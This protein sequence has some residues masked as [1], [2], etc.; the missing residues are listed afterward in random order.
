MC[1]GLCRL[2]HLQEFSEVIQVSDEREQFKEIRDFWR[3]W[4]WSGG[5]SVSIPVNDRMKQL[6]FEFAAAYAKEREQAGRLSGME[7][8]AQIVEQF[9]H[10]ADGPE[11]QI[12]RYLAAAIREKIAQEKP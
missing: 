2:D 3:E 1:D 4:S 12:K 9:H 6:L 11:Y 5:A 8:A 7:Q 10:F